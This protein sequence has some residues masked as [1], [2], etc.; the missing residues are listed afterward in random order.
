[1]NGLRLLAPGAGLILAA[2]L[3]FCLATGQSG[4]SEPQ[5]R[6]AK[7]RTLHLPD[8]LPRYAD[9]ELPA[10]FRT[11][12]V[13]RFDNTPADNPITDAGATLGR[14]LF[15]DTR[16]SANNTIAC[17]SCHQQK[18][19][20]ADPRRFSKGIDGKDGDRNAMSLV[21]ARFYPT[22]RFFW[23]ERASS[24]EKQVLM[25]IQSKAEMGQDLTTL[26]A[27]LGKDER[28]AELFRKAFGDSQ[29]TPDRIARALAQFVRSLVSCNSKYDAGLLKAS[30]LRDDFPN[31]TAQENRGKTLF[32]RNCA[33]CHLPPGQQA[34]F[35]PPGPRNNGLDADGRVADLGVGDVT[36]NRFQAGEFKSPEL[37]NVEFTAPYVHDGRF[38][39]LEDVVEFYSSGVKAHP[40]LHPALRGP[41]QRLRLDAEEKAALVAFL[42]TLSDHKFITDPRFSDP[43]REQ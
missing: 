25:P 26:V 43:F 20:F 4:G 32:L 31:F 17:A 13:R 5:P 42:K 6:P 30:S 9:V 19:A 16:L 34:I 33:V 7:L 14:V 35:Y 22:G 40:N 28:Y 8:V 12:P 10:H 37:R 41:R 27:L 2:Y 1:M 36:F 23:D 29:I 24:L 21:N 3:P 38:A 11:R 15:Y 18:H 39:T